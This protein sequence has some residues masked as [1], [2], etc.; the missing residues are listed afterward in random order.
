MEQ[1]N[2]KHEE[3]WLHKSDICLVYEGKLPTLI[4]EATV[5]FVADKHYK[6]YPLQYF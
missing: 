5:N 6:P 4:L 2:S 3:V 1:C